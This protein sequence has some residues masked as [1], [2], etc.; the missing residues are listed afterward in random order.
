MGW[1]TFLKGVAPTAPASG[2]VALFVDSTDSAPKY[3]DDT[4]TVHTLKGDQG[5]TG[6]KGDTGDQGPKGDTG[7]AGVD[8]HILTVVALG[9]VSGAVAIDLSA[10]QV[11]TL[12]M[13]GNVT[14]SLTNLPAAGT[15]VEAELRLLQDAT[16]GRT[17]TW[18]ANGK[19]PGGAVFV[20]TPDANAL[21]YVGVSVDGAGNW[22]GY[23]VEAIA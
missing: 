19:W 10:G 16:G 11:F 8:G 1:L 2:K 20:P 9:S 4:G 12:T 15:I 6:P 7:A 13:T 23:P 18:P 14:L 21:D 17:V 5:D 22:T 3:V